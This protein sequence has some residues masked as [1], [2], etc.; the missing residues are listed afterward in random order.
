VILCGGSGT[1][2][3]EKC[4][5]A[6]GQAQ[7]PIKMVELDAGWNDLGALGFSVFH[8]D[9][10]LISFSLANVLIGHGYFDLQV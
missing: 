7:F 5:D 6:N 2:L 4:P 8:K 1:R 3:C 10:N 9:I